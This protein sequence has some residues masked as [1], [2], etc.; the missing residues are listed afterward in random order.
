MDPGQRTFRGDLPI[1]LAAGLSLAAAI[2][3]AIGMLVANVPEGLLPRYTLF[4]LA[5]GVR[6]MARR[7]ALVKRL[8]AG[9]A[10]VHVG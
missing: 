1:G 8:P 4:A 10:G 2:S 7:A 3:L 6:E 5:V 9:D